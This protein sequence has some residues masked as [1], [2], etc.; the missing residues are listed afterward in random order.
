M[1]VLDH[2]QAHPQI[3]LC[4]V[5]RST[6]VFAPD[7]SYVS[8]AWR[9]VR[10]C[11]LRYA[12]YLLVATDITEACCRLAGRGRLRAAGGGVPVRSI[13]TPDL[14]RPQALAELRS[15]RPDLLVSAFFDQ[16]L[17]PQALALAPLGSVNIHPSPLPAFRG[18]DPVLQA[19]ASA[20]PE[21]G[22]T[23]H[24][25][26]PELDCG[27]VLARQI[28]HRQDQHSVLGATAQ[29]FHRGVLAL[30]AC[31]PE[32]QAGAPGSPQDPELG[33]YDSWPSPTDVRRLHRSGGRLWSA[34][35]LVR[36]LDASLWAR[37]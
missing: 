2:L 24:R 21:L 37:S 30:L 14:N 19:L 10:R 32:I 22:V 28:Q 25:M 3:E 15:T 31:L 12:I 4:A 16:K 1:L 11:G 9:L 23:V 7:C 26:S 18:V 34:S 20:S 33:H 29:L 35:D 6:R 17:G 13:A 5:V 36:L 27:P 8:G